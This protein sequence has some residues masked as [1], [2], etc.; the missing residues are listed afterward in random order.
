MLFVLLSTVF[1]LFIPDISQI[2]QL[3]TWVR[4]LFH[5]MKLL[6]SSSFVEYISLEPYFAMIPFKTIKNKNTVFLAYKEDS[7]SVSWLSCWLL[8]QE[9]LGFIPSKGLVFFHN[10][11]IT[12]FIIITIIFYGKIANFYPQKCVQ[13][14]ICMHFFI[15]S[16]GMAQFLWMF[17]FFIYYMQYF[18]YINFYLNVS[19]SFK[20]ICLYIVVHPII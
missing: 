15:H 13:V 20:F 11:I 14:Y 1:Y 9:V 10:F 8:E 3:R 16:V 19:S 7:Q 17:W 2:Q 18:K 6:H 4:V 5:S 12:L